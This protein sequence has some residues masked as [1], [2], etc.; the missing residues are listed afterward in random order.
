M[1]LLECHGIS[2]TCEIKGI[3]LSGQITVYDDMIYLCQNYYDGGHYVEKWGYKYV[4]CIRQGTKT[5]LLKNSVTNLVVNNKAMSDE[6]VINMR[7]IALTAAQ[8]A[9]GE[10]TDNVDAFINGWELGIEWYK[11]Q[12]NM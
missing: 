9:F 12:L 7:A 5:Q 8:K 10:D 3:P 11:Q 2:F 1:N 4:W 6:T